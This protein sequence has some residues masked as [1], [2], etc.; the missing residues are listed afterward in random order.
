M[1]VTADRDFDD[2][3]DILAFHWEAG[4]DVAIGEVP[5]D[6]FAE[7]AA[8]PSR[9]RAPAAPAR[10]ATAGQAG[11]APRSPAP[12]RNQPAYSSA[13]AT[14]TLVTQPP[15]EAV[16]G[17]REAARAA[18]SLDELKAILDG[19]EGCA[20]KRTASRLVFADGNPAAKVMF[21]GEAPGRDE[22]QQG[23][24]FV[25]RSGKLLD[26]ML[27]AIGLDRTSAY[28]A[29]VIPWRPPGNRTPTPQET[30]V[31]LPF[32]A[33]QIELADPD[34]LVCLGGPS[35]QA[36]LGTTEGITKL[37]GRFMDYDTGTRT[38][39]AIATFHPAYLLRTPLG[40]R[41]AWRD[42]LAVEALLAGKG[43]A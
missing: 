17:A 6:R 25:G 24:P 23:L 33:R 27:A 38:I 19:F 20:L 12:S 22:D 7:S 15:D 18:T 31:C 14:P 2:W 1:D 32:I 5:V 36:L 13:P 8:E 21:V 43:G 41:F 9:P 29:N 42:M 16:M 35:A 37:R 4:V 40:K 39:R 30:S 11:M 34:I 10:D 28:I 26:L 3:A